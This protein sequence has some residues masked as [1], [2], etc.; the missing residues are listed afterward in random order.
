[1][2]A[3]Q[4][5]IAARETRNKSTLSTIKEKNVFVLSLEWT[6][7][8][9]RITWRPFFKMGKQICRHFSATRV[10]A[11]SE[12]KTLLPSFFFIQRQLQIKKAETGEVNDLNSLL[13]NIVSILTR[14]TLLS[15]QLKTEK[16][17]G[18]VRVTT[19]WFHQPHEFC[20][21][22]TSRAAQWHNHS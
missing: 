10:A 16:K 12:R 7:F 15:R 6:T 8:I 14:L 2:K 17:K 9:R 22:H 21:D 19:T 5:R 4:K 13:R 3:G 20:L 18:Y 11:P 1:M